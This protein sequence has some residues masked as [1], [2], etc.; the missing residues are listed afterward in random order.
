MKA[1]N[2]N[3]ETDCGVN[4]SDF[5]RMKFCCERTDLLFGASFQVRCPNC[6]VW[7]S[8]PDGDSL[9]V[10]HIIECPKFGFF[11]RIKE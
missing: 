5:P 10:T 9:M 6:T 2:V 7:R 3:H 11:K 1:A 4:E 8:P